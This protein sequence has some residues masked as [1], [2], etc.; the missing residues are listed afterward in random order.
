VKLNILTSEEIANKIDGDYN[1]TAKAF[2]KDGEIYI[3]SDLAD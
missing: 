3:N 2:I 1:I